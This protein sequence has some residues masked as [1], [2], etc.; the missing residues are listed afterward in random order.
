VHETAAPIDVAPAAQPPT[1]SVAASG[2]LDVVVVDREARPVPWAFVDALRPGPPVNPGLRQPAYATVAS[3]RADAGGRCTIT[4]PEPDDL[5]VASHESLGSSGILT[6][7]EQASLLNADGDTVVRLM[8]YL[9]VEGLVLDA[10]DQPVAGCPVAIQTTGHSPSPRPAAPVFTGADGR[11]H[12]QVDHA[13]QY[14]IGTAWRT[15]IASEIVNPKPGEP[16][17]VTLQLPGDWSISGT[18]TDDQGALI[19]AAKVVAWPA[20]NEADRDLAAPAPSGHFRIP[21]TAETAADGS[22]VVPITALGS[23]GLTALAPDR[24]IPEPVWVDI[25]GAEAHP[26]VA[27]VLPTAVAI[28]GHVVDLDGA[29]LRRATVEVRAAPPTLLDGTL[30]L[31]PSVARTR[32]T[33]T[34]KDGS[35]SV[36]PLP[37]SGVYKIR[38]YFQRSRFP[39][40]ARPDDDDVSWEPVAAGS[41]DVV[42][43]ASEVEPRQAELR[44]SV[45]S[46]APGAALEDVLWCVVPEGETQGH[47][48]GRGTYADGVIVVADLDR[49]SE[50]TVAVA[51]KGLGAVDLH[52]VVPTAEGPPL[53]VAL[54]PFGALSAT[55]VDSHGAGVPYARIEIRRSFVLIREFLGAIGVPP[56]PADTDGLARFDDLDPGT[57][58]VTA[59]A[60]DQRVE[61]VVEVPAGGRATL[62]LEL[63]ASR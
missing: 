4:L 19:S 1:G 60:L 28:A 48:V 38:A 57:Y 51:A 47:A 46:E 40:A 23:Y 22:F 36:E 3:A 13:T 37:A 25:A 50:Y 2:T 15:R 27:L 43:V 24:T 41:A 18:L 12:V 44:I 14:S 58:T 45:A 61:S 26:T 42:L 17:W 30:F 7:R 32:S 33:T 5:L 8:P 11:F 59:T 9:T 49:E 16:V 55:V 29:P 20:A 62:R 53:S 31:V 56:R 39:P 52:H 63:T 35:F 34:H 21:I 10:A 54:P 6:S